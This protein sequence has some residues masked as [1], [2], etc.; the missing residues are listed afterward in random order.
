MHQC[1]NH[2]ISSG[3]AL[4]SDLLPQPIVSVNKIIYGSFLDSILLGDRKFLLGI[5]KPGP[6][7]D[8]I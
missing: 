6:M 2:Q 7:A 8:F 4:N 3:V 1:W 5:Y